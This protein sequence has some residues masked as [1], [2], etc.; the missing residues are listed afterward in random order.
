MNGG[1]KCALTIGCTL[2]EKLSLFWHSLLA[3]GYNKLNQARSLI[4]QIDMF[5]RH[6]LGSFPTLLVE[7]SKDPAMIIWLDNN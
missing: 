5:R 1:Q 3:T 4:N 6:G 2:E 7:L